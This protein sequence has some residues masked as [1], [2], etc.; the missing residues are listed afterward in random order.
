MKNQVSFYFHSRKNIKNNAKI[1]LFHLINTKYFLR[2]KFINEESKR[3]IWNEIKE[4]P[5]YIDNIGHASV[6]PASVRFCSYPH[7][8]FDSCAP[9]FSTCEDI[10]GCVTTP[11][12]SVSAPNQSEIVSSDVAFT[13]VQ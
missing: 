10:K 4:E 6:N 11:T 1:S 13:E 12:S 5:C 3:Y 9:D 8:E 2:L 7:V